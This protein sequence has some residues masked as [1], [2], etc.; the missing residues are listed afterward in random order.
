MK[1]TPPKQTHLIIGKGEVGISLYKTLKP[2]YT[3]HIRD[4]T[5]GDEGHVDVLHICYPPHKNFVRATQAYIKAYTPKLAIIH[6]TV[7]VGT[8]KKV[9]TIAVHSPI[10][11]VHPNLDK[12]IKI[13]V[14]YFGGKKAEEAARIFK[15]I[16]IQTKVFKSA[17]TT[18]LAKILST[19]N[20][21]WQ[22]IFCKEAARICKKHNV[23]FDEA[24]TTFTQE[25][26]EG[27]KKLGKPHVTRPV[28]KPVAG[29]IG[30]HCVMPNCD[31]LDD[32]MT[33]VIK[34]RNKQY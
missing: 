12:G 34:R 14:K 2:H 30:G 21:A 6:S 19:T 13:F 11:G 23:D 25:Y 3:T 18:E 4:I 17:E 10:R 15:A 24:Y 26:N 22:I 31:L 7:P 29:K 16:G 32:W 33:R 28:L 5:G 20:Y 27:Y 9:G 8:T 1:K